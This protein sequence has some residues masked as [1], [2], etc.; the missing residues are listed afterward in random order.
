MPSVLTF[1][2]RF[3]NMFN[4]KGE[5]NVKKKVKKGE[6][7][8]KK[9]EPENQKKERKRSR[10]TQGVTSHHLPDPLTPPSPFPVCPASPLHHLP[11]PPSAEQTRNSASHVMGKMMCLFANHLHLCGMLAWLL[12]P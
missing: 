2:S 10:L 6:N 4:E 5:Q 9:G 1:F 11:S 12:S 3:C 7:D 8:V